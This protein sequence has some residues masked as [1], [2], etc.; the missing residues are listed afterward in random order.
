MHFQGI[1]I[2]SIALLASM[3]GPGIG[4]EDD[5][6]FQQIPKAFLY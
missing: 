4:K 5:R 2:L 1:N 6:L 3:V